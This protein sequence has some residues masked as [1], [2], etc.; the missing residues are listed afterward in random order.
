MKYKIN[1]L[2]PEKSNLGLYYHFWNWFFLL[3]N[4]IKDLGIEVKFYSSISQKFYEAD[5]L[6]LNSK[7]IPKDNQRISLSYLKKIYSK[8]RN[9][10]WFDMRDSAGTT[11]FEVLP[12]VK[13]YIKKQFY[14]DKTIYMKE[15]RGGRFYTDH[16]TRKYNLTDAV[17]Y[18]Q[19]PL[20]KKYISKLL[21]GWNIGSSFFFDYVNCSKLDYF[22]ELFNFKYLNKTRYN[23][24]LP[25]YSNWED[26][27]DKFDFISLMNLNFKRH[28]VAFQR[29]KLMKNLE[30]I[31]KNKIIS[32]KLSK[33]KYYEV[34][35]NTKISVG[36]Y[37][38]GEVCYRDFEAI[39]CGT[40]F[41]TADMSNIETWPNIY[42][43]GETYLS[44]DLDFLNLKDNLDILI[45]DKSLRK[46]LVD[47]SRSILR[48]VHKSPGKDYFLNK[49]L[50][51]VK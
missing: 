40:A 45:S 9:L 2:T 18:D 5:F 27:D 1:I 25:Y 4:E 21:L 17:K 15:L 43:D 19:E 47:N 32:G 33:K 38:W 22:L 48:N 10:Y 39:I 28:S 11:Q 20:N 13:R 24:V 42:L 46:K 35:R 12:Y 8:N 14:I 23:K 29:Q 49:I 16:Y 26:D 6:F 41:M 7:S 51:I 31:N 3:Q 37:G 30:E 44:Y 50:E 36:A 34:L